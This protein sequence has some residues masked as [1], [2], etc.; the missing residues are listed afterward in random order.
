MWSCSL[1]ILNQAMML[2]IEMCSLEHGDNHAR[3]QMVGGLKCIELN[4]ISFWVLLL[5]VCGKGEESEDAATPKSSHTRS[6]IIRHGHRTTM[7]PECNQK[8]NESGD[9][10]ESCIYYVAVLRNTYTKTSR[11]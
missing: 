1:Y 11:K 2:E 7:Q 10:H 4:Q 9:N 6:R 5:Q 8:K 3:R